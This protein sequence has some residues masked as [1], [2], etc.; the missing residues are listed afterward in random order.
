MLS[1]RRGFTLTEIAITLAVFGIVLSGIWWAA[2]ELRFSMEVNRTVENVN[3]IRQSV[4]S[5]YGSRPPQGL[6]NTDRFVTQALALARAFPQNLNF[7]DTGPGSRYFENDSSGPVYYISVRTDTI[8]NSFP[9]YLIHLHRMTR[10][11]CTR[12]A[13]ALATGADDRTWGIWLSG[14]QYGLPATPPSETDIDQQCGTVAPGCFWGMP[15]LIMGY[16]F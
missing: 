11:Q 1:R 13:T 7:V 2:S 4:K 9:S 16:R 15:C 6:T 12:I 10:E 14:V 8:G 5:F 3:S